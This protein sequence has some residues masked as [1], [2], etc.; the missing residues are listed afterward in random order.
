MTVSEAICRRRSI[1]KFQ[2]RQIPK[3]DLEKVLEAG[4]Y[5]PNAGG[6]QRTILCGIQNRELLAQLGRL[7]LAR[8]DRSRLAG[9]FVSLEQ[10]SAI[11]DPSIRDGFY[12][13]PTVCTVFS[14]DNF[15]YAVPDAF[16]C[17]ENMALA[18]YELG[19]AS[20]II[21]RAE[22]SFDTP[23]GA[24]LMREWEIPAGW[25]PRCF[26][27]LGYAAGPYPEPKPRRDGRVRIIES[28]EERTWMHRPV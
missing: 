20:C 17:A 22:E 16:C 21:A 18:A 10:P 8:F 4:L 26:V 24:R 25:M 1:R 5:A 12:G 2:E 14:P 23:L 27:A 11:D 3:E 15:L 19:I 6:G 9:S 13:A 7:N 28:K